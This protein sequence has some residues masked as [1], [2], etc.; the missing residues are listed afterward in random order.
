MVH[1]VTQRVL[2]YWIWTQIFP[3]PDQHPDVYIILVLSPCIYYIFLGCVT[4]WCCHREYHT[5]KR[6]PEL[7]YQMKEQGGVQITGA[8]IKF[9]GLQSGKQI[10]KGNIQLL[11]QKRGRLDLLSNGIFRYTLLI[12]HIHKWL[13]FTPMG[14][15]WL[16][17]MGQFKASRVSWI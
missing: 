13:P 11:P 7:D 8:P 5:K 3:I 15:L 1:T 12:C 6:K 9:Y 10:R 16:W 4:S 2:W 14:M 17:T